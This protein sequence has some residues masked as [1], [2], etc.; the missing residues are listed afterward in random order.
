MMD[1]LNPPSA[2][3]GWLVLLNNINKTRRLVSSA[4]RRATAVVDS[5][6]KHSFGKPINVVH[7]LFLEP[8]AAV[9][10]VVMIVAVMLLVV[11]AVAVV[12]SPR[13]NCQRL[14]VPA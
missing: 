13:Q 5:W 2:E 14:T 6:S 7:S 12:V 8:V 1:D 11:M 4:T 10:V 9:V 3:P